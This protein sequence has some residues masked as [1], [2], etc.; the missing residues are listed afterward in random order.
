[1]LGEKIIHP[2]TV[3]GKTLMELINFVIL[4]LTQSKIDGATWVNFVKN[5]ESYLALPFDE[6]WLRENLKMMFF[7]ENKD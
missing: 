4:R 5:L 3:L 1:M 7:K 6:N 2:P